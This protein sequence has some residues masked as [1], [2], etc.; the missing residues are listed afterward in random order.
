MV[1]GFFAIYAPQADLW[2]EELSSLVTQAGRSQPDRK[3][4]VNSR[5]LKT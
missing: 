2:P 3:G 5:I 4:N 1:R